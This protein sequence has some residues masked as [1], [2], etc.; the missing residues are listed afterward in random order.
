MLAG[1]K[2]VLANLSAVRTANDV[3]HDCLALGAFVRGAKQFTGLQDELVQGGDG[4]FGGDLGRLTVIGLILV[5]QAGDL[6][7]KPEQR[8][9]SC[10]CLHDCFQ[11]SFIISKLL[12]GVTALN[13]LSWWVVAFCYAEDPAFVATGFTGRRS[14]T[15]A[16]GVFNCVILGALTAV[17]AL[18][19]M[20]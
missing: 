13:F 7:Y 2:A 9:L 1:V 4:V 12:A 15:A 20:D 14:F 3:W 10:R 11:R 16:R 5:L 19:E 18:V 8:Q 6:L 17:D